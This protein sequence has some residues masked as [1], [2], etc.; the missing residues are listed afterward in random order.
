MNTLETAQMPANTPLSAP[1]NDI[2]TGRQVTPVAPRRVRAVF[3]VPAV[4]LMM[5]TTLVTGALA[6]VLASNGWL[7]EAGDYWSVALP[8]GGL[9]GCSLGI[10]AS[11]QAWP[12]RTPAG[13]W[14]PLIAGFSAA[15]ALLLL[16]V[17][18]GAL[19]QISG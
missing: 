3:A 15:A 17:G 19:V 18:F 9:L 14:R 12:L 16:T 11:V 5:G 10:L 6:I 2:P 4:A 8:L 1:W 13:P 7:S